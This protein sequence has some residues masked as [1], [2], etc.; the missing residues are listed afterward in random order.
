M[1]RRVLG[2][3][4]WKVVLMSLFVNMVAIAVTALILPGLDILPGENRFLVRLLATALLGI[5]LGLLNTFVKPILQVITIRLL[6]V[7][8]GL[9]LIITNSIILLLLNW[10]FPRS[11]QVSGLLTA[12]IGGTLIGLLSMFLDYLFGVTQP[13]GYRDAVYDQEASAS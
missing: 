3:F 8:Y 5:G 6:F 9:I 10:L 12:V 13:I 1:V 2:H 4:N 11:L 7:T